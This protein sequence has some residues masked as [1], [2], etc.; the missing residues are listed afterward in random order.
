MCTPWQCV[1][2]QVQKVLASVHD[3]QSVVSACTIDLH[4]PLALPVVVP[5][6]RNLSSPKR[7]FP[8][9]GAVQRHLQT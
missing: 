7:A 9:L 6:S 2:G 5:R 8:Q 4:G 1:G 3:L